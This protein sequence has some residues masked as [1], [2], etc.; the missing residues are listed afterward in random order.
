M[1]NDIGGESSSM[2]AVTTLLIIVLVLTVLYFSGIMG[3]GKNATD[4]NIKTLT[5]PSN[6]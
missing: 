5:V 1:A 3:S 2:R 4:N 6:E